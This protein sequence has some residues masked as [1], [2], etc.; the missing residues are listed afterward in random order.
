MCYSYI[1]VIKDDLIS[2]NESDFKGIWGQSDSVP[3]FCNKFDIFIFIFDVKFLDETCE[4]NEELCFGQTLSQTSAFA[5][6]KWNDIW[7]WNKETIVINEPVRIELVW[8]REGNGVHQ[9]GCHVG[10][11]TSTG[12]K[13][14]ALNASW[15][16]I[17]VK[18]ST[19]T[20]KS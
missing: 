16:R 4:E 13:G 15:F 14:V 1:Q 10:V 3:I 5:D 9:N 7:M 11:D 19:C 8:I 18:E 20:K 2:C 17:G 6:P 12:R